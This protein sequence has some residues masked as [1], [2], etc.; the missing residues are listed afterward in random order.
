MIKPAN[1]KWIRRLKVNMLN[2][3]IMLKI[4]AKDVVRA[5]STKFLFLRRLSAPVPP[6]I[7]FALSVPANIPKPKSAI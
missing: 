7:A 1:R 6:R 2:G 3:I 5:V 4:T